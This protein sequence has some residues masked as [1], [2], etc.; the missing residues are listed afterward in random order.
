ME[1]VKHKK[2]DVDKDSESL[3]DHEG[4]LFM[5]IIL[6]IIPPFMVTPEH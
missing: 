3:H 4:M 1:R 2:E 6:D 5:V